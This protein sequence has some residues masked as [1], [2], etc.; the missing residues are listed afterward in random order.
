M[1]ED[2]MTNKE[3]RIFR[4]RINSD[5][6]PIKLVFGKSKSKEQIKT[7]S[8]DFKIEKMTNKEIEEYVKSL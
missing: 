4:I 5:K 7:K 2:G 6:S 1:Q 8:N 3:K